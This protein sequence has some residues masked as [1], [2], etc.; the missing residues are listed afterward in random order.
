MK[1]SE[2]KRIHLLVKNISSLCFV[3]GFLHLLFQ[4]YA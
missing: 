3:L 4:N 1:V 2:S